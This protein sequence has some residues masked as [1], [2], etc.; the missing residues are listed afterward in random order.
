MRSRATY[1]ARS[2]DW[3]ERLYKSCIDDCC[4]RLTLEKISKVFKIIR[5]S[6]ENNKTF[7]IYNA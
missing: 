7:E 2:G 4:Y 1:L 6:S 3:P 5:L